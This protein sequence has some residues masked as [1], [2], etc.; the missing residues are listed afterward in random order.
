MRFN[1]ASGC[2]FGLAILKIAQPSRAF[3]KYFVLSLTYPNIVAFPFVIMDT[4]CSTVPD[5]DLPDQPCFKRACTYIFMTTICTTSPSESLTRPL[6]RS[7]G[8]RK[9]TR[10]PR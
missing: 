1:H 6:E 7:N 8:S 3:S 4:V 2:L 5:L 9:R 10:M